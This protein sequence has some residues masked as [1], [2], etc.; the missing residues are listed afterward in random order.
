MTLA[1]FSTWC[2]PRICDS[3]HDLNRFQQQRCNLFFL[4]E[5][6]EIKTHAIFFQASHRQP[7]NSPHVGVH[8]HTWATR[9]LSGSGHCRTLPWHFWPL[10][11]QRLPFL[12]HPRAQRC[13]SIA[14]RK[15]GHWMYWTWDGG[16]ESWETR[17]GRDTCLEKIRKVP[18][19]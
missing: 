16:M 15:S 19:L 8:P 10:R 4:T 18:F 12:W 3:I 13:Y 2:A 5:I 14:A 11:H 1:K 17:N 6:Y 7:K 9:P